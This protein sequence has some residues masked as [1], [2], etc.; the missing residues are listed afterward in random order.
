MEAVME[1]F[2]SLGIAFPLFQAQTHDASA[3]RGLGGCSIC[4]ADPAHC[5]RLG[6]GGC[7]V[8]ACP[9]CGSE[10][11]LSVSDDEDPACLLCQRPVP[12]PALERSPDL[13]AC[14][15]CLRSGKAAFTIDTEFGMVRWEDASAGRT[16]GIPADSIPGYETVVMDDGWLAARVERDWLFE[17]VRTPS[18]STW[19][20]EQ[21]QFCCQRPMIYLGAWT[22]ADFD[23]HA[24]DGDGRALFAQTI[25]DAS[26]ALW[27]GRLHDVA[28]VYVFR[29]PQCASLKGHWDMA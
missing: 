25:P 13:M 20:G 12:F 1:T 7:L 6:V 24:P 3:Y 9:D 11:A 8:V 4:R 14:Y 22:S 17:L 5:F 18:Y 2:D 15:G 26:D 28:G 16:F 21:W 29:C 23:A 19:Q 27:T 10:N